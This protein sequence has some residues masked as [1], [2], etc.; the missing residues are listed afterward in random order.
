MPKAEIILPASARLGEGSLWHEDRLL[1][2]DIAPGI[3]HRFDPATGRDESWPLGQRVGTVVPRAAGGLVVALQSGLA[4]FDPATAALEIVAPRPDSE[5]PDNRFNDGKCDPAGRLWVGTMD[6]SGRAGAGTLYRVGPD[7]RPAPVVTGVSISNGLVWSRDARTFFYIDTPTRVVTAYDYDLDT[8][9]IGAPRTVIRI[10][11][12]QG[13]PD[14]MTI[15]ADDRL[16]IALW[17]G[18]AVVCADPAT[19]R[20]VERIEIPATQVTSCAF[21]GPGLADLYI[22]SAAIDLAPAA[23]AAE[24]AAG[25]LFHARPGVRGLPAR[26]F[27]G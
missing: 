18:S 8:G 1:W 17:G 14:G 22:T 24:P 26:T 16:W 5:Q 2:V 25:H 7:L 21:G 20:I 23:L 3:L 9:A 12:G 11:E 15:D 10:P 19:G 4:F 13:Y 27:A 6:C